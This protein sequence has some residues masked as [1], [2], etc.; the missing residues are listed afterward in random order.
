MDTITK[1]G[2]VIDYEIDTKGQIVS[3]FAEIIKDSRKEPLKYIK[4]WEAPGGGE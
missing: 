1:E 2:I 4:N 3:I